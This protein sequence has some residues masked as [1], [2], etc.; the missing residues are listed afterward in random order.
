M[1][2]VNIRGVLLA[3][4]NSA[5]FTRCLLVRNMFARNDRANVSGR[6]SQSVDL[7]G[8]CGRSENLSLTSPWAKQF[9]IDL[10]G[11]TKPNHSDSALPSSRI[12]KAVFSK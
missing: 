12:L 9:R 7:M 4:T 11:R 10:S 1:P 3:P 5:N 6:D 2:S 8:I